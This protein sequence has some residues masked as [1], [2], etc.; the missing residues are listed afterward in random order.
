MKIL[1]VKKRAQPPTPLPLRPWLFITFIIWG[2]LT[3]ILGCGSG[4]KQPGNRFVLPM[5]DFPSALKQSACHHQKE[6]NK[7]LETIAVF[8]STSTPEKPSQLYWHNTAV[9]F[10]SQQHSGIFKIYF[11]HEVY[12]SIY[13]LSR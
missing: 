2:F 1:P 13:L 4:W 6:R 12:M 11:Y 9:Y 8:E 7:V 5:V 3:Q 10:S